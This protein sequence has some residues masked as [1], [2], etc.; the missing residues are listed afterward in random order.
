LVPQSSLDCSFK[1]PVTVS[2]MN[3]EAWTALNN[4]SVIAV[5]TA[6]ILLAIVVFLNLWGRR[7]A[8]GRRTGRAILSA[9]GVAFASFVAFVFVWYLTLHEAFPDYSARWRAESE[10]RREQ[11]GGE[12]AADA[13][14]INGIVGQWRPNNRNRTDY[15]AF[16]AET[17]SSI[18]PDHDTTIT[19]TYRVLHRDGPCMRIQATGN[20]V[21]QAGTI[22]QESSR[23]GD[24]FIVCVDPETDIMVI[25]FE[26]SEG[27]DVFFTRMD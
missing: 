22:T 17:Y 15:L 9:L 4:A 11:R 23:S 27:G 20:R 21:I 13:G 24:P 7:D 6:P 16:T 2:A 18:N 19:Y 14:V 1:L 12:V 10:Q 3:Y 8:H 26:N 25:R 5:V